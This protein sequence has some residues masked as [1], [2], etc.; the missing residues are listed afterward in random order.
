MG[1]MSQHRKRMDLVLANVLLAGFFLV[2]AGTVF[3]WLVM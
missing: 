2:V 3:V 1:N